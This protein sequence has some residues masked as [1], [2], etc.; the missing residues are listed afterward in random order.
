[1][2]DYNRIYKVQ[3]HDTLRKVADKFGYN[4]YDLQD[5][6][7]SCCD[8]DK[9]IVIDIDKL[10]EV[11][12]PP[13]GF[14]LKKGGTIDLDELT[15]VSSG[16]SGRI[17]FKP[18][19]LNHTYGVVI[20]RH[21]AN[22]ATQYHYKIHFQFVKVTKNDSFEIKIAKQQVYIN[23]EAPNLIAEQLAQECG[24]V[25]YPLHL[26]VSRS[27][28]VQGIINT[29]EIETR[30]KKKRGGILKYYRSPITRKIVSKMD[31]VCGSPSKLL[32]VIKGNLFFSLYFSNLYITH[33][34]ELNTTYTR[35]V[36]LSQFEPPINYTIA[37]SL[38]PYLT[39]SEKVKLMMRGSYSDME[40]KSNF[41]LR[42]KLTPTYNTI[43]SVEGAFSV[44]QKKEIEKL[45]VSVYHL[46]YLE[47]QKK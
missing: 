44:Q 15:R 34:A 32:K 20:K 39:K 41:T 3:L 5:Y 19:R 27:A 47:K 33:G 23:N 37:Q 12:L 35:A 10:K 45:E 9:R 43:F 13:E 14:T 46:E 16:L 2:S 6:H 11:I 38:N 28:N 18:Q 7:N 21:K 24:T 42:Y 17:F 22:K 26:E 30:W 1:M 40:T 4:A 29:D 25:L 8:F 31:I 36:P